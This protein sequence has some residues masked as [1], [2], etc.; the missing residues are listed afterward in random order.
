MEFNEEELKNVFAGNSEGMS[1]QI[2]L[3][4]PELFREKSYEE[5]QEQYN[6]N[7]Q[8]E[9]ENDQPRMSR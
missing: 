1:E 5:L 8:E 4:H 3:E 7:E 9:Y 2:A 6:Q